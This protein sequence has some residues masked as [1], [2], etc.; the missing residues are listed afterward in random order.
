M[1]LFTGSDYSLN[2]VMSIKNNVTHMQCPSQ[3][4]DHNSIKHLWEILEQQLALSTTTIKT[5][6]EGVSFGRLL[7]IPL[8]QSQRIQHLCHRA[9]LLLFSI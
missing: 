1:C 2:G 3:S 8:V 5:T 6:V 4:P 9:L 7:Y